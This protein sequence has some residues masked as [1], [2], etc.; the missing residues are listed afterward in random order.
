MGD[1]S[2][3]A[4]G[5]PGAIAP[6][7]NRTGLRRGSA[8]APVNPIRREPTHLIFCGPLSDVSTSSPARRSS[9]GRGPCGVSINVPRVKQGGSSAPLMVIVTLVV[10]LVEVIV[11]TSVRVSPASSAWIEA[12]ALSAE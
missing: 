10:P 2:I 8:A 11:N 6:A 3:S 12:C 5:T 9:T 4:D 7:F 1:T